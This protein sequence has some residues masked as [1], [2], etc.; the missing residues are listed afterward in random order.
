M[1]IPPITQAAKATIGND[2]IKAPR[3]TSKPR[4]KKPPMSSHS[5]SGR[6]TS[7]AFP[8]KTCA[9]ASAVALGSGI[10]GSAALIVN[11]C[12]G[13]SLLQ[14]PYE[15]APVSWVRCGNLA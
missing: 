14:K 2:Q 12:N 8:E 11:G 4:T 13:S 1:R 7:F 5:G 3:E 15:I 6:V 10:C 9:E